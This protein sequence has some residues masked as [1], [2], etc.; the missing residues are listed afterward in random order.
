[1]GWLYLFMGVVLGSSV[2]PIA[3]AIMWSK[4]NRTGALVGAIAGFALGLMSWLVATAT[5]N[6]GVISVATYVVHLPCPLPSSECC[7]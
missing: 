3:C 5:L 4:A 2:V 7:I 1:M 6:D